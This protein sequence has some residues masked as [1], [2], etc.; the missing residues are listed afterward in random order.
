MREIKFR[1]WDKKR[2][3]MLVNITL[4][5]L[6]Y[7][8]DTGTYAPSGDWDRCRGLDEV[9]WMQFT[10]LTDK[11]G[12]E[13]YEGDIVREYSAG[14]NYYK[15]LIIHDDKYKVKWGSYG[16]GEYVNNIQC[17]MMGSYS[18]SDEINRMLLENN[19]DYEYKRFKEYW[20]E[21]IGNIYENP[22]LINESD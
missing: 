2:N 17:W 19:P 8:C 5:T 16:D 4:D 12:K 9:E 20:I 6:I 15:K 1:A 7:N 21:V 18:L 22:E 14:L 3:E 13:I 11:N 10:G